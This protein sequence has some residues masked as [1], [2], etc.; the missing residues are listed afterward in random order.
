[1]SLS[2]HAGSR[3]VRLA[4]RI[5]ATRSALFAAPAGPDDT[6]AAAARRIREKRNGLAVVCD[7]ACAPLGIVSVID[8]N[9]VAAEHGER[10]PG[11]AV[12]EVMNTAIVVC[13]PGDSVEQALDTMTEPEIR[14]LPVVEDRALRGIVSIREL[15][16]ARFEEAR[17]GLGEMHR[18]VF[19]VG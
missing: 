10:A 14:H 5:E 7:A 9:R 19:G 3:S 13:A 15:L 16:E 18:D 6:A 11:P 12:R 4:A 1:V 8:I 2:I 17:V